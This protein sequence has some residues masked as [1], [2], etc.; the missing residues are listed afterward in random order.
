MG[1]QAVDRTLLQQY[2]TGIIEGMV[3]ETNSLAPMEHQFLKGR[4]RE[5]FISNVL[6]RFLTSQFGV[7]SGIV[8]SQRGWQS[9]E[10]DILIYDKRLLPPF[11]QEGRLGV[12]PIE[13]VIVTLE[14]KTSV[15]SVDVHSA[16]KVAKTFRSASQTHS[17]YAIDADIEPQPHCPLPSLPLRPAVIPPAVKR[18]PMI[19]KPLPVCVIG[20]K[21]EFPALANEER[22]RA[23][24]N[25]HA[26]TL[27]G[28]CVVGSYSWLRM[29]NNVWKYQPHNNFWEETKRFIAVLLDNLWTI[30]EL[31]YSQ[32]SSFHGDWI[33]IYLRDN[34]V[35]KRRFSQDCDVK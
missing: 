5:I 8:V 24:L 35:I 26:S 29:Q 20:L 4:F 11:I 25:R 14:V 15:Q 19:P 23:W 32:V 16:E 27:T 2:G 28:I 33:G 18:S 1:K 7:G 21:N 34:P 31:N 17:L 12:Y 10:T 6:N 9:T 13:S 22:G 3:A 30:G